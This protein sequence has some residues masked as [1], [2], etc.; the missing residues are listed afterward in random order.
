MQKRLPL[1]VGTILQGRYRII[2]Q[3]GHG[4]FGAVYEAI[5]DEISLSF[6]LKET[7]YADHEELRRAFK[8]E[9]RMLASLSHDAFPRVS[10]YFT[11]DD[12]CFLVM[13]LVRGDDL[14]KLLAKRSVPFE[15]EQVLAWADQILDALEDLHA[16]GIVHR[17]IKPSN[18]KLTPKRKIKL[19]DFGI[20]KGTL[21][22]DTTLLTTVGS[23][24][25]ATV[26]YAPLEQVLRASEH[27]Q[28]MLAVGFPDKVS[29]ILQRG[30]DARSDL[31]ALG[32]TLYHL[33]TKTLPADVSTRALAIWSGQ[34]DRLIPA[35]EVNAQVS[36]AI[37]DVLQKAMKIDRRERLVSAAEMRRMLREAGI[38]NTTIEPAPTVILPDETATTNTQRQPIISPIPTQLFE[39]PSTPLRKAVDVQPT[40]EEIHQPVLQQ[41][42]KT[43]IRLPQTN[44]VSAK[45]KSFFRRRKFLIA[46]VVLPLLVI[47]CLGVLF[48]TRNQSSDNTS[49]SVPDQSAQ[50]L[51]G[52]DS[53]VFDVAFSPDGKTIASASSDDTI[54]LWDAAS[55]DLKQTLDGAK[56]AS[57]VFSPDSKTIAGASNDKTIKLWD[58]ASGKLNQVLTGHGDVVLAVAFS[59]DGKTLASASGDE[60][61]KLW[62]ATKGRLNQTLN[63]SDQYVFVSDLAF[64]PNGKTL[65]GAN[66][67]GTIELWDAMDGKLKTKLAGHDGLFVLRFSPDGKTILSGG[68]DG[69]IILRDAA[70]GNLKKTIAGQYEVTS[71]AFSPDG[72]V[73]VS[74]GHGNTIKLWD[75]VSGA[76]KQ[77]LTGH[78]YGIYAVA[79]SPNG[80]TIASAGG[81]KAIKLWHVE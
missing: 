35:H 4:G 60:T 78:S 50:T 57:V 13:E 8:R 64:S 18:L 41:D 7:F 20:A 39:N 75:V 33:L 51:T 10:H 16:S 28:A 72:K 30:T 22:G 11:Q 59:P 23:L 52:H 1:P 66:S 25:A 42:G 15:Q 73:F 26:Q 74:A 69:T 5:D 58:V 55:G 79:F 40:F 65:A 76:L 3:L 34:K 71:L 70:S 77:T 9:A 54:K 67:K 56:A 43:N 48:L 61:I 44:Q 12:G 27:Y 21:E 45:S 6:A 68:H 80:K 29:E 36:L 2:R 32:A 31:Y 37:S 38:P 19:L 46:S 49:N 81:D 47:I 53:T 63:E 17:D 62:D 24:A 14:D